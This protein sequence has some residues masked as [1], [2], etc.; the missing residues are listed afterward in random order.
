MSDS[1][2]DFLNVDADG[3]DG[4]PEAVA[5]VLESVAQTLR[6]SPDGCRYDFELEVTE[7]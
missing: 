2:E 4:A 6:E 5:A 7:R 3:E 1:Q